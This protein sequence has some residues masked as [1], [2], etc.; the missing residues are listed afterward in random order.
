VSLNVPAQRHLDE[1]IIRFPELD[2]LRGAVCE[3]VDAICTSYGSGGKVLICGNGGSAADSEHIAGELMKSFVLPRKLPAEDAAKLDELDDESAAKLQ[4]GVPAIALTGHT[5]LS[6]A[7][8][9]DS[10]PFMTFAQQVYVLGKPEDVLL[11]LSTS[12]NA[13]NV[14]NAAKVAKAFGITCVA[15]TGSKS[16]ELQRLADVTINVP[17][18]ETYRVQ[19]YHLPIYHCICLMAEERLFNCE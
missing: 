8:I 3:C 2:Y 17:A 13:Q 5:A 18:A 12:G 15:F 1:L 6:T 7:I 11:A 9:N 4:R 16:S 14:L 10:D 19:E